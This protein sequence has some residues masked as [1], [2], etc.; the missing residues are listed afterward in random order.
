MT[1]FRLGA[2]A[3]LAFLLAAFAGSAPTHSPHI[4][5]IT[6]SRTECYGTCPVYDLVLRSDGTATYHGG[7]HSRLEGD[8]TGTFSKNDFAEL[9]HLAEL[10][11]YSSFAAVYERPVT[12]SPWA[13]TSVVRAGQRK[14]VRNYAST[15]PLA[16]SA[17]EAAIDVVSAR[18]EWSKVK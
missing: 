4:S 6:L 9:V 16:L 5:E 15:G 12:D 14:R 18:A 7:P 11:G 8:W 17:F 10:I 13:I 2:M 1:L 3:A